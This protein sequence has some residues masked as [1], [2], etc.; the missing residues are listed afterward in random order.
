MRLVRL[1]M[2]RAASFSSAE[3]DQWTHMYANTE[4]WGTAYE[5]AHW[6]PPDV[7]TARAHAERAV[8]G[9]HHGW[10]PS[11]LRR[12][13]RVPPRP[14]ANDSRH[15]VAPRRVEQRAHCGARMIPLPCGGRTASQRIERMPNSTVEAFVPAV[16]RAIASARTLRARAETA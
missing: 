15:I 8:H 13:R 9:R 2:R 7:Q 16:G 4:R 1:G 14:R 3:K 10:R 5:S 12:I 11:V 6:P